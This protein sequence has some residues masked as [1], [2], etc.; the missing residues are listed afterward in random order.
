MYAHR[1]NNPR[2]SSWA[3]DPPTEFEVFAAS[4]TGNWGDADG[5]YWG[6]RDEAGTALGSKGERLAKFPFTAALTT[7][8]HGYP[9]SP[10]SGRESEQPPDSL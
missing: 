2:K 8:W 10:A 1:G 9:V 6:L 5:H 3:I 4:D 7:P